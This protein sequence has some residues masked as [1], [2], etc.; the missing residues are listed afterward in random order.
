M[1]SSKKEK[2]MG[3]IAHLTLKS[4]RLAFNQP[5]TMQQIFEETRRWPAEKVS[6]LLGLLSDDLHESTPQIEAAW[7]ETA[8]RRLEELKSGKVREIPGEEV[9]AKIRKILSR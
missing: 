8:A 4:V 7:K 6:Q 9:R 2:L 1:K 3:R 5:L